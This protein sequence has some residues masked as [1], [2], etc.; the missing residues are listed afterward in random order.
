MKTGKWIM[1]AAVF[2]MAAGSAQAQIMRREPQRLE[3]E[4]PTPTSRPQTLDDLFA[5]L[6][7]AE[8]AEEAA[9]ISRLIERRLTRS[10]SPTADLLMRR[11]VEMAGKG[12][13]NLAIELTDRVVALEPKWAHGWVQRSEFF[14]ALGDVTLAFDDLKRAV[15]VEP[16][17][18]NAWAALGGFLL[19]GEEERAA[20]A[21]FQKALEIYPLFPL[22]GAHVARLA[23]KLQGIDI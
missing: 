12:D 16:R 13:V 9:G 11:A 6:K 14:H 22:V 1:V 18:F 3:R 15:V 21:A 2:L 7:K 19:E 5:R 17:H 20:L 8:D 4:S 23:R 10:G